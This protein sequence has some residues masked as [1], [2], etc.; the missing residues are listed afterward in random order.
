MDL[1]DFINHLS[2]EFQDF[3]EISLTENTVLRNIEGW[4]SMHILLLVSMIDVK[5][6]VLLSGEDLKSLGTVK[7]LFEFVK[8]RANV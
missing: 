2:E 4:N 5:Y 7:E 3:Q 6:N 1:P 8:A